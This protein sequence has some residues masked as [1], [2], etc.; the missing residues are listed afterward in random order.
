MQGQGWQQE[1]REA[2][3]TMEWWGR[4]GGGG[5]SMVSTVLVCGF[6]HSPWQV[7]PLEPGASWA[8]SSLGG[9]GQGLGGRGYVSM[10]QTSK[11]SCRLTNP[12]SYERFSC[13]KIH[14]CGFGPTFGREEPSLRTCFY[15]H[16]H[17]NHVAFAASLLEKI[18]FL[19]KT[20]V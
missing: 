1:G 8:G 5:A 18:K 11:S 15:L 17:H 14:Q 2:C 12:R 6:K 16:P 20:D 4:S 10:L 13:S 7:A 3:H 9:A 19:L